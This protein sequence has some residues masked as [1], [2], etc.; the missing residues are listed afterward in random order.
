MNVEL[1]AYTPNPESIIV[2]A[3][4]ICTDKQV[5][6]SN[7]QKWIKAGHETPI[8]HASAT[9]EIVGISRACSHQLVRHRLAS[10][11]QQSQRY[12]QVNNLSGNCVIPDSISENVDAL[13]IYFS[14]IHHIKRAYEDLLSLGISKEDSRMILP[15]ATK[16]KMI[17]SAN[18]REFRH[19]FKMRCHKSAQWEIRHLCKIMLRMLYEIAPNVFVDLYQEYC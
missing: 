16:T 10:Y 3:Y 15:N 4:G 14:A 1:I 6:V 12:C 19:I 9:F 5:P 11:S 17:L 13:N 8:E 7:I 18:F 2:R